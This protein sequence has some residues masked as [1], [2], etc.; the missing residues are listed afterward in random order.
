MK[1][2]VFF[3]YSVV[4]YAVFLGVFLYA[5]GFVGNLHFG[6][7]RG[8][9]FVPTSMDLGEAAPLGKA[10]LIDAL[11]LG[12]FAL[13][14]SGMARRGF[15]DRWTQIIP[16]PIERST[17]VLFSSGALALMFALW[18]PIGATVWAFDNRA[19]TMLLA[20][21]SLIGWV[22]ALLSTFHINHFDLFGLRQT[23]YPLI[24]RELPPAR[25]ATPGLYK[26]VR[27]PLYLGFLIAFWSTPVMTIGHLVF[28]IATTGYILVAI[29]LEERDLVRDFGPA[30]ER[31]RRQVPML[32]PIPRRPDPAQSGPR[33]EGVKMGS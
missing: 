8:L 28:A 13:Q 26:A 19:V 18:R 24:G 23:F 21:T 4:A 7:W 29:Q 6:P 14:H 10:L 5:V 11:L 25:F 16:R 31:Y 9:V 12:V 22:T 32:A 30:Y 1:R 17:Y 3:A 27:H 2:L 20:L 15:K 33:S